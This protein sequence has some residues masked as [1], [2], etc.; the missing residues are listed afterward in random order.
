MKFL[1]AKV[2]GFGKIENKE[3]EFKDGIN[4][5]IGGNESGKSTFLEFINSMLFGA[6]K[7]KRGK[8]I[9][10]VDKYKPWKADEFS[11]N[12]T[13][14]LDNGKKYNVFRD[15]KKSKCKITDENLEDIT[16]KF[17]V[18][19]SK[20]S[21]F[22]YEQT[23]VE[24]DIMASTAISRQEELKIDEKEHKTLISKLTNL[25]QTGEDNT[26]FN[27]AIDK[28]NKK[29]IEEV[30]T[31]RTT[32]RPI[33]LINNKFN[34]YINKENE[35]KEKREEYAYID[36]KYTE[37]ENKINSLKNK[38]ELN[39]QIKEL[40]QKEELI[41]EIKNTQKEKNKNNKKRL[42]I[43]LFLFLAIILS[44]IIII[45]DNNIRIFLS[46]IGVSI[47]GITIFNNIK[48]PSKSIIIQ[49]EDDTEI[50]DKKINI[51]KEFMGRV[52]EENISNMLKFNYKEIEEIN[53][54]ETQMYNELNLEIHKIQFEKDKILQDL[55]KYSK[56]HEKLENIKMQKQEIESLEYS[57][58]L[59]INELKKAYSEMK[60]EVIPSITEGLSELSQELTSSKYTKVSFSDEN[61]LRIYMSD[62]DTTDI[63]KLS[64]GTIYQLYLALRIA[65]LKKISNSSESVPIILDEPFAYFDNERLESALECLKKIS[66]NNQIIIFSCNDKEKQILQD[67][68]IDFN[69]ICL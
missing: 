47:L 50:K 64:T 56:D 55:E 4:I 10:V 19:K 11:G 41:E 35:A 24:E 20:G 16:N 67:K 9:S 25:I 52:S 18:D 33:N 66:E 46:A 22:F 59:A 57:I 48:M 60:R 62:G 8:D 63:N 7:N 17:N 5:I 65:I 68:N 27:K 42:N 49:G 3:I 6:S 23:A 37:I 43:V 1:N 34:S 36:K 39:K 29:L 30:G 21:M 28:L 14:K 61:G 38:L 54:K 32:E 15:F 2:N 58:K 69:L 53:E 13:Y 44:L 51:Y 40:K 31:E 45:K 12:L 26:S